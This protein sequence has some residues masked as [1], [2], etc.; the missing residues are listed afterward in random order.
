[1]LVMHESLIWVVISN[2]L[3]LNVEQEKRPGVDIATL[4]VM[5]FP[6][7]PTD[8]KQAQFALFA[9]LILC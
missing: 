6:A 7:W 5:G 9:P 1:M 4:F 2:A 8:E 3:L